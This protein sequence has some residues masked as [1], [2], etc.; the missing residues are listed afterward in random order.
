MR[1]SANNAMASVPSNAKSNAPKIVS[2]ADRLKKSAP[3]TAARIATKSRRTVNAPARGRSD[4][5]SNGGNVTALAM[6]AIGGANRRIAASGGANPLRSPKGSVRA[7]S[8]DS[9]AKNVT[10]ERT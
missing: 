2:R 9:H 4:G 3:S 5:T 10:S 8:N 1:R 6:T 7:S